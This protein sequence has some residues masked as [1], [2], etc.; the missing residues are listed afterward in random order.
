MNFF[1]NLLNTEIHH[2]EIHDSIKYRNFFKL[3][4][5]R[6]D[7]HLKLDTNNKNYIDF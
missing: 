2:T 1:F 3:E 5:G 7:L 4:K 6:I